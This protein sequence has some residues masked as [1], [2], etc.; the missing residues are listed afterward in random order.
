MRIFI[1]WIRFNMTPCTT[2]LNLGVDIVELY[3]LN[4]MGSHSPGV[5][6]ALL[7]GAGF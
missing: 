5:W 3:K 7:A 1:E 2:F 4:N 6:L